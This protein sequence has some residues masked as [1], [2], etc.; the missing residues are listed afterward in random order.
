MMAMDRSAR[1]QWSSAKKRAACLSMSNAEASI[2]TQIMAAL[3]TV[4][5]A[6][7]DASCG[8]RWGSKR[9]KRVGSLVFNEVVGVAQ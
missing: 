1:T 4:A 2:T 5:L 7:G 8:W 6:K 3:G 9:Q